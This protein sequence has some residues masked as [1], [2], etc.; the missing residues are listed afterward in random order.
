M[1]KVWHWPVEGV[2]DGFSVPLGVGGSWISTCHGLAMVLGVKQHSDWSLWFDFRQINQVYRRH[3]SIYWWQSSLLSPE[4]LIL[5]LLHTC[6]IRF[7]KVISLHN[8]NTYIF[9]EKTRLK[10][11]FKKEIDN[12]K[13]DLQLQTTPWKCYIMAEV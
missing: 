9:K 6:R 12:C 4:R 11:L 8:V 10:S 1:F 7:V 2:A 3:M 13:K 5:R